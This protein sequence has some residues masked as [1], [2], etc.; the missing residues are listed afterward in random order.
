VENRPLTIC[1]FCSSSEGIDPAFFAVAEDLGRALAERGH[2]LVYGGASVGLMGTLARSVQR[3]G[4]RVVGVI[5]V[6]LEGR[7]IAFTGADELIVTKDLRDRKGIMEERSDA[8]L[9]LPGGFGTLEETIEILTLRQLGLHHKP[10]VILNTEGF[11]DP[12]LHLFRHIEREG[13][14]PLGGNGLYQVVATVD[15]ALGYIERGTP[16]D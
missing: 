1:V 13:F 5:P 9:T 4:G 2:Q 14:A 15:E 7:E 12:L 3:H 11:Y 6:A 8:F 16:R 10:L